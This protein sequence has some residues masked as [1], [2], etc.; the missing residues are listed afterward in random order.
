MKRAMEE[1]QYQALKTFLQTGQAPVDFTKNKKY[2]LK[3]ASKNFT[4]L[5]DQLH[6]V[7]HKAD[8]STYYR[9]VIR[10]K[11]EV[12]RVFMECH[13]TAG[14]HRGRDSTVGKVK[15]RYYWPNQYKEIEQKVN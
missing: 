10:G 9:L 11:E 13:M 7:S 15:A 14:G 3:R 5:G 2:I 4:L 8:G 12:E 1:E 6:Y